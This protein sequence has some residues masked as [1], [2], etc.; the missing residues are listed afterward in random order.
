MN[1]L[2]EID[3]RVKLVTETCYKCHILFAMPAEMQ[4]RCS[5]YGD[6]FYCP[7]GHAQIYGKNEV[8]E[9][10]QELHQTKLTLRDSQGRL[11][12][13]LDEVSKKSKEIHRMKKRANAG[14]CQYCHRHFANVERHIHTKHPLESIAYPMSIVDMDWTPSPIGKMDAFYTIRCGC[15]TIFAYDA[16]WRGL[17]HCP[18]CGVEAS[19]RRMILRWRGVKVKKPYGHLRRQGLLQR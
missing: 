19:L 10:R 4:E 14:V 5:Q 17:I 6:T 18:T 13:A 7:N 11:N 9:L 16:N 2:I 12:G 3:T 8:A 1:R 15:G